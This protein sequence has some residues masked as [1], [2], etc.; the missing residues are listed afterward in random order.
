MQSTIERKTHTPTPCAICRAHGA[1]WYDVAMLNICARC[2]RNAVIM[3]SL[4]RPHK[5]NA[6]C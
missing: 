2:R 4:V 3:A 5:P 1:R 6:A